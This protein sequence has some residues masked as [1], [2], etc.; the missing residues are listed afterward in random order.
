MKVLKVSY[1]VVSVLMLTWF[2]MS[3]FDI[4]ADNHLAGAVHHSWNLFTLMFGGVM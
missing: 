2:L 4:V 3:W 1:T